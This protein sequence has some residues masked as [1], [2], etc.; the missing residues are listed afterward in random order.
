MRSSCSSR[1]STG[2]SREIRVGRP[3]KYSSATMSPMT[4]TRLPLNPSM[5]ARRRVVAGVGMGVSSIMGGASFQY[6]LYCK[7]WECQHTP[8][9]PGFAIKAVE[10]FQPQFLHTLWCTLL[11]TRQEIKCTP[12]SH[13]NSYGEL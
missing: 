1:M 4:S 13:C 6:D 8:P 12:D 9:A 5:S 7:I 10:P 2:A 11:S 3:I